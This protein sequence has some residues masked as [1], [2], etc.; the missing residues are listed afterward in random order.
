[1]PKAFLEITLKVS[2]AD[3]DK[4]G[5]VY[6]KYKEKVLTTVPG[7]EGK[8]LLVRA[9]DVQVLHT[10]QSRATAEGFLKSPLFGNTIAPELAPFLKAAPEIRIYDLA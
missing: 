2:G 4:A 5:A 1:M 6:E 9:E 8:D 3:R 7:A 10:F